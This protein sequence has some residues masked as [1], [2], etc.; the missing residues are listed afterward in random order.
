MFYKVMID[1]NDFYQSRPLRLKGH[2]LDKAAITAQQLAIIIILGRD[3]ERI[4][5]RIFYDKILV[6]LKV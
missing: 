2:F 1:S 3:F 6:R 4:D 5:K